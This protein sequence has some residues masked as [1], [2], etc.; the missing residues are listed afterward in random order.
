MNPIPRILALDDEP[1]FL[2]I[3]V[4][5]L[6]DS[7]YGIE[8]EQSSVAAWE[9]L[10]REPHRFDIL[11][12]DWQMPELDGLELLQRIKADDTLRHLTGDHAD[13][14]VRQGAGRGRTGGRRVLLPGQTV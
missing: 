13:R 8:T 2:D 5:L 10:H 12:L 6:D 1:L 11:L 9:R 14:P 7:G 4:E 3:I